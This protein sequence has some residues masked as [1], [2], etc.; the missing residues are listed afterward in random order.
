MII[1]S[2]STTDRLKVAVMVSDSQLLTTY[3]VSSNGRG[4]QWS[5]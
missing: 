1:L 3:Q 5:C 4:P 2:A